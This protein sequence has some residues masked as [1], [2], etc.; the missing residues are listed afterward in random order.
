MVIT[1]GKCI[2]VLCLVVY[3]ALPF[4]DLSEI[5]I[6]YKPHED[7]F[8]LLPFGLLNVV[9]LLYFSRY[10][11]ARSP[12]GQ[13]EG[14]HAWVLSFASPVTLGFGVAISRFGY[15]LTWGVL[16]LGLILGFAA[17]ALLH[18][19]TGAGAKQGD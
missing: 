13:Q 9:V 7:F 19:Q 8:F 4:F 1:V 17:V 3:A 6:F 12:P 15:P 2:F 14:F 5:G 11:F 16:F 18:R 10:L